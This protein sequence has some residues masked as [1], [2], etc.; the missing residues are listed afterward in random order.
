MGFVEILIRYAKAYANFVTG[1]TVQGKE[2]RSLQNIARLSN[3]ARQHFILLLA[4]QHL[5]EELF[6]KLTNKIENL[7]FCYLITR[8]PTKNFERNFSRWSK[9]LREVRDE[10]GLDAFVAEYFL[11]DMANRSS[12]FD[13]AMSELNSYRIQQYRLRYIL[14]KL[15][16]FI[17]EDAWGNT[18]PLERYYKSV[19]IEHILPQWP[20]TELRAAFDKPDDY[21]SFKIMLG[22]LTL[23]EKS[24]NASVSNGAYD[25]KKPGYAQSAILLTKSLV[26][27][28]QVGVNTQINRATRDLSQFKAWTSESIQRRQAM[29]G[30]LARKVWEIPE[31]ASG[32]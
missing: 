26:D 19:Q 15:S 27:S 11:S 9:E 2:D 25:Q 22:N 4:A 31:P 16:Q 12:G 29:L 28:S 1:K 17:D 13:F 21:D 18:F 30:Q 7:F 20:A 23:L 6:D 8:E 14:A 10:A 5:P 3:Q 24:I 32:A